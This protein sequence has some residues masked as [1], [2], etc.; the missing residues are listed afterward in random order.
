MHNYNRHILSLLIAG[1]GAA[2][3]SAE[4]TDPAVRRGVL[5]NGLTYYICRNTE[6]AGRA[7]FFLSRGI[8]SRVE[9][10]DEKG[11]AHFLEHMCFNGSRHFPDNKLIEWLESNG[12]KFGKNLNAHTSADE[13]VY[14]ISVVPAGRESLLDSCLLVLRDWSDG[15]TLADA[16]IDAERGVI[17]GEWRHR[18]NASSRMLRRA[19]P[20]L[21]PASPYGEA[22]P[23]G[24]MEVV[25]NFPP[26]KL[27][28]FYSTWYRPDAEAVIV[29]GDVD[30]DK[31]EKRIKEIFSDMAPAPGSKLA[32][33]PAFPGNRELSVIVESDSEQPVSMIQL[34]FKHEDGAA[35]DADAA[36]RNEL[37]ADL[38]AGMMVN[39]YDDVE[40][41]E[42]TPVSNIGTGDTN[43][44]LSSKTRAYVVRAQSR[45]G[46]VEEAVSA[47][48][49]EMLRGRELG[50]STEEFKSAADEL[51]GKE[52]TDAAKKRNRSNTDI[53]KAISHYYV[54]GETGTLETPDS[55]LERVRRILPGI[56]AVDCM[57][58]LRAVIN[59]DGRN[60]VIL[61]YN[62]GGENAKLPTEASLA[63]AFR[64][65]RNEKLTPYTAPSSDLQLLSAEPQR[66]RIVSE[67]PLG[68]FDA[69]LLTLSNGVKVMLKPTDYKENQVF[70]RGVGEGGYS[71]N[72]TPELAPSLK[73][74][75][76]ALSLSGAGEHGNN[77]LKRYTAGRDIKV[78]VMADR[79][80]ETVEV[81][82]TPA[83][84]EDAMRLMWLKAT[85]LTPDENAFRA[86]YDSRLDQLQHASTGAVN[87]MGELIHDN[88][89]NHHPLGHKLD[90]GMLSKADYAEIMKVYRDRFADF[91]D[92]T[93]YITGDFDPAKMRDLV[94]R[95]IASLPAAGRVEKPKDIG[96]RF[97]EGNQ[98]LSYTE[99][100]PNPTGIVYQFRHMDC[101]YNLRN[102]QLA[103]IVGQIL[104]ARLLSDLREEKGW[105]YSITTHGGVTAGMRGDDTAEFML[106]VYIKVDPAHIGESAD[107]VKATLRDMADGVSQEEF[108]KVKEYMVKSFADNQRDNAYWLTAM[109]ALTRFGQDFD[110]P[111]MREMERITPSDVSQFVKTYVLPAQLTEMVMAPER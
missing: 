54:D 25:E 83:D 31:I 23:I 11:L 70:V 47:L 76:E 39:R 110:E 33:E 99:E 69:T 61:S 14:N 35:K 16:A 92:F 49:R 50:F 53:A 7:D 13:T 24:T 82:T 58:W 9:E 94:E 19:L 97:T 100:M 64:N 56:T 26:Q 85:Q 5:P 12:V 91:S 41:Q 36:L 8:G 108:D 96:Y 80:D 87:R 48:W 66:G 93:F 60:V 74:F 75:N 62:N 103:S 20:R 81:S 98:N 42:N 17:K 30:P 6:P 104:K 3:M 72:Y 111:Y 43:F 37:I 52:T 15:L 45:P 90:S 57:E 22:M 65:V 86:W 88:V 4:I 109:R 27:R 51:L 40:L 105:T 107:I 34:Y 55:R 84:M 29:A 63:E 78:S 73:I 32:S 77:A 46:R 18:D 1:L 95:Y 2:P 28:D 21:Y 102:I 101:P 89:Y 38:V 79:N 106:P 68:H 44:L 59:P 71:L 10:A 67:E